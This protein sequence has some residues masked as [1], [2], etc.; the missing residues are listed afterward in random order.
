[1]F[2]EHGIPQTARNWRSDE[3]DAQALRSVKLQYEV[4]QGLARFLRYRDSEDASPMRKRTSKELILTA[5]Q[6]RTPSGPRDEM[7]IAGLTNALAVTGGASDVMEILD[8][9]R[10]T[11]RPK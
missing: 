7:D 11:Y 4:G 3:P 2:L 9:V 1:V 5:I 6:N 10:E 8:Y